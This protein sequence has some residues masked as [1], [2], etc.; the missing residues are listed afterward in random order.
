MCDQQSIVVHFEGWIDSLEP[1]HRLSEQ[2]REATEGNPTGVFDGHEIAMDCSH[3]YLFFYTEDARKF[4][5]EVK[6]ILRAAD[7]I[8]CTK[9]ILRT[10]NVGSKGGEVVLTL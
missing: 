1:V 8:K 7:L 9:A 5:E 10:G 6:P 3:G 2:L 4:F